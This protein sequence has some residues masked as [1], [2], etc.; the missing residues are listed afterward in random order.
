MSDHGIVAPLDNFLGCHD[1]SSFPDLGHRRRGVRRAGAGVEDQPLDRPART[2]RNPK[3]AYDQPNVDFWHSATFSWDGKVANFID[4]S[5]GDG[6]PTVTTKTGG[7][8]GPPK[9]YETGNMFFFE[10]KSGELLSEYRNPRLTNDTLSPGNGVGNY[11]SSHLG[12]PVPAIDRYL[13]VNAY[14]RG[15]SSVIDF[16]DPTKP[17][18]IAFADMDGHEHVVGVHLPAPDRARGQAPR[19]LQ[20]RPEPQ[21]LAGGHAGDLSRGRVRL[22]ALHGGHRPRTWLVGFDRLNPQLQERVIPNLSNWR[23]VGQALD[24]RQ[25]Q[26]RPARRAQPLRASVR[27]VGPFAGGAVA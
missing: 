22:H 7:L 2:P 14:Y 21:L 16:S 6:C 17:K 13:L 18:E 10:T 23:N 3:W 26:G 11:C 20:R 8:P 24:V 5:F 9:V 4:E 25:G 15:G 1:L 19:L 27:Q 12:I